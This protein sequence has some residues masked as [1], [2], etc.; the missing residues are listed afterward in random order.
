MLYVIQNEEL[1]VEVRS[2]GAELRSI[3][4]KS[5][6]TEYLWNGDPAWWKY[7][8]PILFPIVGKLVDGKYRVDGKTYELPAHGLARISEFQLVEKAPSRI[9]FRLDA[10]EKTM[11]SYPW[12]FCLE[13]GYELK[14]R[15]IHVQWKVVNEDV[16]DMYFSIGAHPAFRC[17]IVHGENLTDCYL[18]FSE[19]EDTPCFTITSDTLLNH[20]KIDSLQG[21]TQPLSDEFFK[22]GVRAYEKLKSDAVTIKSRKSSKSLTVKA[23]GFTHWG[24]WA[25]ERGGS[26]FVCI[27]PWFGHADFA[28]FT[29]EFSEKEGNQM[30]ATNETFQAE[31]VIAI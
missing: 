6:E 31:Y 21:K 17:P 25:P 22:D 2:Q 18:E 30:L 27:E 3:K 5:D 19:D 8:S 12:E 10:S 16:K 29:G 1:L 15:E 23:P 11:K 9:L 4:E 20:A 14:D 13:I 7:S 28:D 24:F 26:P